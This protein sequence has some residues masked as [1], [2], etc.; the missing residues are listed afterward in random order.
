VR[1]AR[2]RGR[3]QAG[4]RDTSRIDDGKVTLAIAGRVFDQDAK[5]VR[6]TSPSGDSI[7][8]RIGADGFFVAG[9]EVDFCPE[10]DWTPTFIAL[11]SEAEVARADILLVKVHHKL[12]MCGFPV[13]PHGPYDSQR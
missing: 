12:G 4:V 3:A 5:A 13:G 11:D 10:E 2:D 1:F 7:E 8:R 6:F 9:V